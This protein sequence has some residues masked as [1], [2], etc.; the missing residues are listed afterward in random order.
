LFRSIKI[1]MIA[2]C[3]CL[4]SVFS[5]LGFMG[6]MGIPLDMMTIT[7]ASISVG[8]AVDDTIHYI[9]RF[10]RE[11]RERG[12]SYIDLMRYCHGNIGF[13]MYYTSVVIVI[14]FS[15]LVVSNFIPTI[16]FGLLTGV[17]MVFALAAN[18]TLLPA[19]IIFIQPFGPERKGGDIFKT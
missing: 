10:R 2:V 3:P 5:V 15:V 17:A 18:L 19:L 14:G 8:I 16:Y 11:F 12:G 6:W 4:I 7:I 9:H 1:A 13:A